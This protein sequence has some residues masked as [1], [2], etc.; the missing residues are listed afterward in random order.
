MLR[1]P[2]MKFTLDFDDVEI[3]VQRSPFLQEISN[4]LEDISVRYIA[5][6]VVKTRCVDQRHIEP[7]LF[8]VPHGCT[9]VDRLRL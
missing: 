4:F 2:L 3:I 5:S 1:P 8:V 6:G 9:D 7:G